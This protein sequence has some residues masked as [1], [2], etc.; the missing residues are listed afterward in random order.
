MRLVVLGFA[1]EHSGFEPGFEFALIGSSPAHS[2]GV[3]TKINFLKTATL[4][5]HL[6]GKPV[7]DQALLAA[8]AVIQKKVEN[9]YSKGMR[10]ISVEWSQVVSREQLDAAN[11]DIIC[12]DPT[13]SMPGP[14]RR[15]LVIKKD[16]IEQNGR[17]LLEI[18]PMEFHALLDIAASTYDIENTETKAGTSSRK[19]QWSIQQSEGFRLGRSAIQSSM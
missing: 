19:L 17:Q 16:L 18:D 9:K 4:L 5:T 12:Q 14:G 2:G 7:S 1:S 11:V 6:G 10:E 13:L 8:M 3:A 15:M